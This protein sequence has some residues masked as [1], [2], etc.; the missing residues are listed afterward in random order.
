MLEG[1][2]GSRVVQVIP[3][4]HSNVSKP[5]FVISHVLYCS[6]RNQSSFLF[7]CLLWNKTK[8]LTS[9]LVIPSITLQTQPFPS[10][11]DESAFVRIRPLS[12]LPRT[13]R[14]NSLARPEKVYTQWVGLDGIWILSQITQNPFQLARNT[15]I[16]LRTTQSRLWLATQ[17]ANY[18]GNYW[19]LYINGSLSLEV[20][21]FGLVEFWL[22]FIV[23]LPRRKTRFW[24]MYLESAADR[25]LR[26]IFKRVKNAL[27]CNIFTK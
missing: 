4:N 1:R 24:F 27:S 21:S 11:F 9:R 5:A 16:V 2:G 25:N 6:S 20:L 12:I 15:H 19:Q 7:Y 18:R 8:K 13:T 26:A 22:D 3:R 10:E 23:N 14:K 17:V